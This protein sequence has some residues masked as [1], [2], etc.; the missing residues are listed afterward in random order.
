MAL[1]LGI[2]E[3]DAAAAIGDPKALYDAEVGR[4]LAKLGVQSV[5]LLKT[6]LKLR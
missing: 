1:N 3:E 4:N 2:K 5:D 6:T